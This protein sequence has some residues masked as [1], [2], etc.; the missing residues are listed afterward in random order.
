MRYK[1][2]LLYADGVSTMVTIDIH[3]DVSSPEAARAAAEKYAFDEGAQVDDVFIDG[4][5]I[6][7]SPCLEVFYDGL[8]RGTL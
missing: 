4:A 1:A 3:D 5:T 6:L 8:E 2:R 7:V